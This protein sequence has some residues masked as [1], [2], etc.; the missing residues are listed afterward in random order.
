MHHSYRRQP[1]TIGAQAASLAPA[2]PLRADLTASTSP[3]EVYHRAI[4]ALSRD[5]TRL[6]LGTVRW[7]S[8]VSEHWRFFVAKLTWSLAIG[9]CPIV[10]TTWIAYL[11]AGATSRYAFAGPLASSRARTCLW[12]HSGKHGQEE[13]QERHEP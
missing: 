2:W 6:S 11:F 1:R 4:R 9:P 8:N 10:P 3:P 12:L 13:E 7:R 5:S